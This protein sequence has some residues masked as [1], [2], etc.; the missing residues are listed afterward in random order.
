MELFVAICEALS[1][2][3]GTSTVM[4]SFVKFLI[5][6]GTKPSVR[7]TIARATTQIQVLIVHQY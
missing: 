2:T 6:L 7:S 5:R 1:H 4:V 3:A